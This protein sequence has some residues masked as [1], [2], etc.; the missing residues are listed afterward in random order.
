MDIATEFGILLSMV[1]SGTGRRSLIECFLII[2]KA[3]QQPRAA[4]LDAM[5]L[6]GQAI[7]AGVVALSEVVV[8][9]LSARAADAER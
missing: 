9:R 6:H 2:T 5:H 8:K 7:R 1:E 3:A 4:G